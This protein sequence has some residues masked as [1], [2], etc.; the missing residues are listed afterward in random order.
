M[1]ITAGAAFVGWRRKS[2]LTILIWLGAL[3]S[4]LV[5]P[6]VPAF[7]NSGFSTGW[8]NYAAY[9][10]L[11]PTGFMFL[12][13]LWRNR[14]DFLKV[15]AGLLPLTTMLTSIFT[16]STILRTGML[17]VGSNSMQYLILDVFNTFLSYGLLFLGRK[18][19]TRWAGLFTAMIYN[20]A[21]YAS[22]TTT[23]L[24]SELLPVWLAWITPVGLGFLIDGWWQRRK[25]NRTVTL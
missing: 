9:G 10:L 22:L 17:D 4:M 23:P 2:S 14:G 11:V 7:F 1:L 13:A 21:F 19:R 8:M 25:R 20:I 15:G 18:R 12:R 3:V 6:M 5:A 16:A 24:S